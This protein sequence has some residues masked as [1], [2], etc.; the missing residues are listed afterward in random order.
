MTEQKSETEPPRLDPRDLFVGTIVR[1]FFGLL[2]FGVLSLVMW[3]FGFWPGLAAAV[4]VGPLFGGADTMVGH[5][6]ARPPRR[7][8]AAVAGVLTWVGMAFLGAGADSWLLPEATPED[9]GFFAGSVVGFSCGSAVFARVVN[10]A[11]TV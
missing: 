11:S 8:L 10:G 4:F 9:L 3:A 1:Q 2:V 7:R 6:R 5:Y